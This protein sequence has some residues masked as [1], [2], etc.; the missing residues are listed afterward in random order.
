[1]R[2]AGHLHGFKVWMEGNTRPLWI[3]ERCLELDHEQ[4]KQRNTKDVQQKHGHVV[5]KMQN[6]PIKFEH[7]MSRRIVMTTPTMLLIQT[8]TR[9]IVNLFM[10]NVRNLAQK[11][12]CT[13]CKQKQNRHCKTT[14]PTSSNINLKQ[15]LRT[16]PTSPALTEAS[17]TS[18]I[19]TVWF[20]RHW[21][22]YA[23]PLVKKHDTYDS[24]I[25]LENETKPFPWHI[26]SAYSC[27]FYIFI[28]H[29]LYC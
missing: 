2:F 5:N 3:Y 10:T 17:A 24:R 9:G 1:M 26:P 28:P 4:W 20:R 13:P 29:V 14:R 7:D 19:K 23:N 21:D 18:S 8:T 6:Y 12:W 25:M 11:G 22:I 15:Y 27:I 16:P